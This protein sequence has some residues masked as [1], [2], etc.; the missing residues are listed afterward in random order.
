MPAEEVKNSSTPGKLEPW[1]NLTDTAIKYTEGFNLNGVV[2][3]TDGRYLLTAQ[4]NTGNLYRIDTQ[5]RQ[6]TPVDLEGA[7]LTNGDGQVL[8]G[9]TLY[10][11]R[12]Q[13]LITKVSLDSLDGEFPSG[14]VEGNTLVP[15]PEDLPT[16]AALVRG[17][18]LVVN[19]QFAE[20]GPADNPEV[21]DPPEKPF[22]VSALPAP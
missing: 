10:V 6:V 18:L 8:K 12:N 7:K 19:S 16:T 11:V 20:E 2:A 15:H 14:Q 1:L 17:R 4:S 3:T 22:T 9:D 21:L 13:G 5:T